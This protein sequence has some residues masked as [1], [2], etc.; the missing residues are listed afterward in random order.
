MAFTRTDRD[1]KEVE[2]DVLRAFE[3]AGFDMQTKEAALIPELLREK[4][5]AFALAGLYNLPRKTASLS[6][7]QPWLLFWITNTLELLREP[8]PLDAKL[9]VVRFLEA[10]ICPE[11][12]A[13]C[14]G[15][16]QRPHMAPC[17]ASMMAITILGIPEAYAIIRRKKLHDFLVSMR[18]AEQPGLFT[19]HEKGESDIRAIY[20]AVVCAQLAGVLD[21]AITAGVADFIVRS[22]S[23]E[24][25]LG[26]EPYGEA[27]GGF[28]FCGTAVMCILGQGHRLNL[29]RLEEWLTCRQMSREGG[30]QGRTN[31]LVDSCYSFWQ[32]ATFSI[33]GLINTEAPIFDNLALQAYILLA[34]QDTRRGGLIDK[35]SASPDYYHTCYA[36][37]GLSI[38]QH[39]TEPRHLG[40]PFLLAE[41]DP[42]YNAPRDKVRK[43]K[44]H[45]SSLPVI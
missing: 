36:L 11:T 35:P 20:C 30:F 28:T 32:S 19:M 12:G 2:S 13:F 41:L 22:Q 40:Q 42:L 34:C 29:A 21:E 17:Y 5:A 10:C 9:K 6:A 37:G 45:F 24:G 14:G 38:S 43:I 7:G 39:I 31:K 44:E 23:Y 15:P 26:A 27:H 18:V 1:Q 3:Q 4:H 16:Y 8:L 33:L 25:G